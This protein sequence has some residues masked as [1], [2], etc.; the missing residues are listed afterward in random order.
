MAI[1]DL[2]QY[3]DVHRELY[4]HLNF[5]GEGIE[6]VLKGHLLL[7]SVLHKILENSA[8]NQRKIA[9][10]DLSFYKLACIVQALFE[11]RCAPWVWKAV[12]DLNTIRNKIAHNLEYPGIEAMVDDFKEYVRSHDD[13]TMEAGDEFE[14]SELPMAI[15]S[16]HSQLWRLLDGLRPNPL[17]QPT[18][19][20]AAGASRVG[21]GPARLNN[22]LEEY[23]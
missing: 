14:F 22:T 12:S 13:G 4:K 21:L 23:K 8:K 2:K 19:L 9:A 5:D 1:R 20:D 16:V 11:D 15:V 17:L 10:A 3:I 18:P 7:E 6:V